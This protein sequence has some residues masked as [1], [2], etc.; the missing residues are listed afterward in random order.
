MRLSRRLL[1]EILL[2]TLLIPVAAAQTCTPGSGV[3]CTTNLNLWL[4][5]LNYPNWN[6]NTNANWTTLD[7]WSATVLPLSGGTMTGNLTL[8]ADPTTSLEAATKH[9]VDTQITSGTFTLGSTLITIGGTTTSVTGLTL[10]GVTPT[11]FT[12]LD[13]TS[14]IQTQLNGKAASGANSDISSILGLTTPLSAAQGGTGAATG[15]GYAYGNGTSPF[16]F[17]TTIP[18]SVLTGT[19]TLA[20]TIAAVSHEWLNSYNAT[21]GV[22]TQTQPTYAD[23]GGTVPTWNQNTTGTAA[24]VTG[25]VAASNGG[26]GVATGTGYA[27]GNGTSPFTFST[28]I[29]VASVTGAAP[30]ASPTFTGT[31]TIPSGAS[32]AGFSPL[33][34]PTFTGTPAGPTAALGTST[35]QL[36]TTAF[37]Q[38]NQHG[39][40]IFSV[41]PVTAIVSN[42]QYGVVKT[43]A[44]GTIENI[45]A[46]ASQFTCSV[47]PVVTL[48]DCGTS[49]TCASPTALGS[50]TL[51]AANTIIDGTIT[52]ATITSGHYVAWLTTAGTCTSLSVSGSSSY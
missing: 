45:E 19:P 51:T 15:T 4:L 41:G 1:F 52:S 11:T 7:T 20:A 10:N 21:T 3:T 6:T 36:A 24:N 22:F 35:T 26:T 42:G 16:T 18:Y 40:F 31:V 43:I 50:V 37:V 17:S 29:P 38:Q 49:T 33:N 12:Y 46:T 9:Y 8:F 32:I 28:A 13:P 23:I 25:V 27:Y 14:S 5:P 34:S 30:L 39:A 47:N 44:G 48:E 2:F